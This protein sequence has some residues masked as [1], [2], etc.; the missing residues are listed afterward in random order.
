MSAFNNR[1]KIYE[2]DGIVT[3]ID[4]IRSLLNTFSDYFG[5]E[6]YAYIKSL[7]AYLSNSDIKNKYPLI[8]LLKQYSESR[9]LNSN[10]EATD[11]LK[12]VLGLNVGMCSFVENDEK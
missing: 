2:K 3:N 8:E 12:V 11:Y 10:V 9:K 4:E 6:E 1:L 7:I 5:D